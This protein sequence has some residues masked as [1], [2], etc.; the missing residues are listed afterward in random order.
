MS[1]LVRKREGGGTG[2]TKSLKVYREELFVVGGGGE[3]E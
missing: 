2:T 3:E 1:E